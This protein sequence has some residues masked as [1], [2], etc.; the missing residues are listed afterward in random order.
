MEIKTSPKPRTIGYARVS[1][2]A[3]C[4]DRQT[5]NLRPVCDEVYVEKVS[6]AAKRRPIFEKVIKS[7]KR[8]D[9]L[10]L[11]DFDRGFRSSIDA[12][13]TMENLKERGVNLKILNMGLDFSTEIGEVIFS[14]LAALS[15]FERRTISRRT[16]EGLEAARKRGVK[17]GRPKK[18]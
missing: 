5:Q 18:V 14:I 6:G 4:V 7:L 1:L 2:E 10:V 15:Q 17:L 3:M 12:L 13:V 9:T 8:H 16:K 11:L